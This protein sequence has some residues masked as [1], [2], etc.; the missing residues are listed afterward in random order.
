MAPAEVTGVTEETG[1]GEIGMVTETGT[2]KEPI[3]AV[4]EAIGTVIPEVIAE[5][6]MKVEP[7]NTATTVPLRDANA[8]TKS[9]LPETIAIDDDMTT[10]WAAGMAVDD[11]N[12]RS[13][14]V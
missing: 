6:D 8:T 3:G 12:L 10:T 4:E 13:P 2:G 11:M 14:E 5:T 7:K 9:I 1:I